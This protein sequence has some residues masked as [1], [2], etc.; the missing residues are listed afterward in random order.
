MEHRIPVTVVKSLDSSMSSPLV[1]EPVGSVGR[2]KSM[3]P[4]IRDVLVSPSDNIKAY[5]VTYDVLAN[6]VTYYA[7]NMVK[8]M[9]AFYQELRRTGKPDNS[10]G[11]LAF[12]GIF[13]R[14]F[15]S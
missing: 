10:P 9:C 15:G 1:A 4:T 12:G 8:I 13:S 3:E 6:K 5:Q 2:T 11:A 7:M 14:S